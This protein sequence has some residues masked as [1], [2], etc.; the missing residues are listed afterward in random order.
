LSPSLSGSPWGSMGSVDGRVAVCANRKLAA[1]AAVFFGL[2]A[3]A[4]TS[5]ELAR[6]SV[7][8]VVLVLLF[9]GLAAGVS[10]GRPSRVPC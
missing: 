7:T 8:G 9:V 3:G 2:G 10:P 4:G 1:G 6:G 5:Q